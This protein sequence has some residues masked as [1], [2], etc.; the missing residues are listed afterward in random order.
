MEQSELR[1]ILRQNYPR[2]RTHLLPAL[3]LV[4]HELGH[5]PDW[6]L[7][8]VGWHLHVPAS[9]VY[10]AATSYS[11]LRIS[12]P[13]RHLVRVCSGLSC[14]HNGGRQLLE[15]LVGRLA[16]QPG[17]TTPDGGI[18]LEESSCGFLCPMAPAVEV[19]GVWRGRVTA[20]DI[21]DQLQGPILIPD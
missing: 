15:G 4:R 13:G 16:I 12:A 3:H 1:S 8:V 10:G 20:E 17:M 6:A 18:T 14:W 7:Q 5:L 2:E 9:E 11:E 19:D 21:Y